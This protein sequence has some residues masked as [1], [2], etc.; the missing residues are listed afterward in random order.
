MVVSVKI[1]VLI[2]KLGSIPPS[3]ILK[4]TTLL[5]R[6]NFHLSSD[7]PFLQVDSRPPP[8]TIFTSE[9]LSTGR[10]QNKDKDNSLSQSFRHNQSTIDGRSLTQKPY[11]PRFKELLSMPTDQLPARIPL[12]NLSNID[13]CSGFPQ[14]IRKLKKKE[15]LAEVTRMLF[16]E[17]EVSPGEDRDYDNLAGTGIRVAVKPEYCI[18]PPG[19]T[20]DP[21]MH[22]YTVSGPSRE[23]VPLAVANSGINSDKAEEF[24]N[25]STLSSLK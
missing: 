21:A 10:G 2:A 20:T 25:G 19:Y 15:L 22:K 8:G 7:N 23:A 17:T 5:G 24:A 11:Q 14:K 1:N 13:M 18:T 16:E 6:R 12:S 9:D 4:N 3:N